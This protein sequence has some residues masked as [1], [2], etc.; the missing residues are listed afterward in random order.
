M[1]ELLEKLLFDALLDVFKLLSNFN[2]VYLSSL[3]DWFD[4][5]DCS[6]CSNFSGFKQIPLSNALN[7][8]SLL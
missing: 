3:L 7:T 5:S 1:S 6:D 4:Y 2:E 8:I